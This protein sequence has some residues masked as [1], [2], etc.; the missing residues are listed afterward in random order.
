MSLL[1]LTSSLSA[2]TYVGKDA[3]SVRCCVDDLSMCVIGLIDRSIG[4]FCTKTLNGVLR[5]NVDEDDDDDSNGSADVVDRCVS[6][7]VAA[8]SADR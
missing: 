8:K 4:S 6:F 5:S 3:R 7:C 2:V 1:S